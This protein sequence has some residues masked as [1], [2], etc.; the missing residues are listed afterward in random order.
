MKLLKE[1]WEKHIRCGIR[2]R[3]NFGKTYL[4]SSHLLNEMSPPG[5]GLL[6]ISSVWPD[7]VFHLRMHWWWVMFKHICCLPS[8]LS[9]TYPSPA[10]R[11]IR[12]QYCLCLSE[13]HT[14]QRRVWEPVSDQLSWSAVPE[15]PSSWYP[16]QHQAAPL[17]PLWVLS[18]CCRSCAECLGRLFQLIFNT[19]S[20]SNWCAIYLWPFIFQALSAIIAILIY[21][22]L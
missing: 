18:P 19:I 9:V 13:P 1:I 15:E 10:F 2:F 20:N 8:A 16:Q 4:S 14:L 7:F 6:W 3:H 21:A 11:L 17:S 12:H 22:I 5:W